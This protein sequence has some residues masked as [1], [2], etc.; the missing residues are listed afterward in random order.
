MVERDDTGQRLQPPA[1]SSLTSA[2]EPSGSRTW[3][4]LAAGDV[5]GRRPPSPCSHCRR[6]SRRNI[7]GYCRQCGPP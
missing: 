1:R 5:T 3:R 6:P 4:R 2:E 7:A